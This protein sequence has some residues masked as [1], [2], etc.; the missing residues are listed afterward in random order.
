MTIKKGY[1]L[2][3]GVTAKKIS[4]SGQKWKDRGNG[5]GF[6]YVTSKTTKYL[7]NGKLVSRDRG[8]SSRNLRKSRNLDKVSGADYTDGAGISDNTRGLVNSENTR[9]VANTW[10]LEKVDR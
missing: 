1:C 9:L 8:V 10:E 3:H 5:R 7:C 4:V 2:S 6:G